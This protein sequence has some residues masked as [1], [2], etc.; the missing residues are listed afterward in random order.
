MLAE[1]QRLR[2][3]LSGCCGKGLPNRFR[4]CIFGNGLCTQDLRAYTDETQVAHNSQ[5]KNPEIP[6]GP[7]TSA[8][9]WSKDGSPME[10]KRRRTVVFYHPKKADGSCLRDF[11]PLL[12]LYNRHVKFVW[13]HVHLLLALP[14]L[15]A[16]LVMRFFVT[17]A[18]PAIWRVLRAF[19][20]RITSFMP[21]IP[22][23]CMLFSVLLA[24]DCYS[25]RF[26]TSQA[27]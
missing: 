7:N 26:S 25:L 13:V 14:L 5:S 16:L 11:P 22:Y 6:T 10:N 3:I 12:V 18:K 21:S 24:C 2:R 8:M 19:P 17:V 15:F 20:S 1:P 4:C 9:N 23:N 27:C